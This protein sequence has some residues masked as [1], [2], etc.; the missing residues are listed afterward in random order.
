MLLG[1]N[2]SGCVQLAAVAVRAKPIGIAVLVPIVLEFVDALASLQSV[3]FSTYPEGICMVALTSALPKESL[4]ESWYQVV[5]PVRL[6][7]GSLSSTSSSQRYQW[8]RRLRGSLVSGWPMCH[9]NRNRYPH[10]LLA[11]YSF[12]LL[13]RHQMCRCRCLDTKRFLD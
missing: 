5:A 3:L 1:T 6:R 4:S 7:L 13:A 11:G 8:N 12:V 9:H 10:N 2:V